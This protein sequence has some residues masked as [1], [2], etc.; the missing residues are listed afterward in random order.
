MLDCVQKLKQTP[1]TI[2]KYNKLIQFCNVINK[3]QADNVGIWKH[4]IKFA[5]ECI[6]SGPRQLFKREVI[7]LSTVGQNIHENIICIQEGR[8]MMLANDEIAQCI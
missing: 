4:R 2:N 3:L 5:H 6:I 7:I 1:I 8:T